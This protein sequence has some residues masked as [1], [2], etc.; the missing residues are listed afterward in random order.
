MIPEFTLSGATSICG[1]NQI[2]YNDKERLVFP[3]GSDGKESVCNAGD[4]GS[5]PRS[6]ICPGEGN[7]YPLQYTCLG[8]PKDRGDW[9]TTVHVV[10]KSQHD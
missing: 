6:G 9:W 5:I 8:I 10:T 2:Q 3:G 1:N 4:L 7:G